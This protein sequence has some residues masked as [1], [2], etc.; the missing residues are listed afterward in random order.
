MLYYEYY[1]L[2]SY[3]FLIHRD[4]S[5]WLVGFDVFRCTVL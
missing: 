5:E 1:Y 2:F 4:V 3:I